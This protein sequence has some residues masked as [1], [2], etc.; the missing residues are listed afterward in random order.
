MLNEGQK[1]NKD[2]FN[3]SPYLL[4]K[5]YYTVTNEDMVEKT[6]KISLEVCDLPGGS[7]I[8]NPTTIKAQLMN[9]LNGEY[10]KSEAVDITVYP[11]LNGDNP[12]SFSQKNAN[13]L[14]SLDSQY[15]IQADQTNTFENLV[16]V[17]L[18]SIPGVDCDYSLK[19]TDASS[20]TETVL[21]KSKNL[22]FGISYSFYVSK[23]PQY[24]DIKDNDISG[25]EINTNIT[26]KLQKAGES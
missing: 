9:F 5:K 11:A 10:N 12:Y 26:F 20:G 6:G 8:T 22:A 23:K 25:K 1:L 7:A 13:S 3:D 2:L 15:I 14:I 21:D 17:T 18:K 4:N 16:N 24:R 19:Y